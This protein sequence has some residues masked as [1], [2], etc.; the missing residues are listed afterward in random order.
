[1]RKLGEQQSKFI[2]I[3]LMQSFSSHCVGMPLS[4]CTTA[5][6]IV[7]AGPHLHIHCIL[8]SPSLSICIFIMIE[9]GPTFAEE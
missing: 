2:P 7:H 5:S 3:Q 4:F 6:K 8:I 1:M 9:N